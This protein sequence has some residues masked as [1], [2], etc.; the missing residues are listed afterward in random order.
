MLKLQK[1]LKIFSMVAILDACAS[2]V[3]EPP[4]NPYLIRLDS[5]SCIPCAIVNKT[6]LE[7]KCDASLK[8]P[9]KECDNFLA[10]S[11]IEVKGLKDYILKVRAWSNEHCK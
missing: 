9:V 5:Q 4:L 3:P 1:L 11:V 6:S 10:L 7:F 2:Q 8:I